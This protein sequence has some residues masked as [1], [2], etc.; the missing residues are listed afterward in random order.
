MMVSH[1]LERTLQRDSMS[2][3]WLGGMLTRLAIGHKHEKFVFFGEH[4]VRI[5][6]MFCEAI[7]CEIDRS[8]LGADQVLGMALL[9][10][11]GTQ[12][13]HGGICLYIDIFSEDLKSA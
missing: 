6:T 11:V 3:V 2:V 12:R 5:V 10:A 7:S 4:G 8:I 1:G 9:R 13:R